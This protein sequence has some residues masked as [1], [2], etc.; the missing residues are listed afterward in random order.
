MVKKIGLA[1][2]ILTWRYT[3]RYASVW[4]SFVTERSSLSKILLLTMFKATFRQ[5][6]WERAEDVCQPAQLSRAGTIT[7][8]GQAVTL[9]ERS[10]W[11]LCTIPCALY[12]S[13]YW[14]HICT[15]L[16]LLTSFS[17]LVLEKNK[18][19]QKGPGILAR[20]CDNRMRTFTVV[21]LPTT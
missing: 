1:N 4:P 16:N 20:L 2:S 19:G 18:N 8:R 7:N 13:G 11:Q 10:N 21:L 5:F 17:L 15:S 14:L 3:S 6:S 12:T 9:N